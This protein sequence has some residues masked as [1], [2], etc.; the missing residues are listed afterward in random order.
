MTTD[1]FV[2][3]SHHGRRRWLVWLPAI[4]LATVSLVIAGWA[5]RQEKA[6]NSDAPSSASPTEDELKPVVV[7]LG[8]VDFEGGVLSLLPSVFGRVV[9]LPAVENASV[10]SGAV[11]LRI[12]DEAARA[13]LAEAEAA[14]EAALAQYSEARK[15]PKR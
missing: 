12:D 2:H 13:R 6:T 10:R 1:S 15:I 9:D 5:I 7:C 4:A 14:L 11:L 3:R 8:V